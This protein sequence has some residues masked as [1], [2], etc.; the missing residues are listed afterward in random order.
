[1]KKIYISG[2]ISG[3]PIESVVDKFAR[4]AE[5]LMVKGFEPVNPID[6]SPYHV[7]KTWEDYMRDDI[8]AL[9]KCDA[10]YMLND[11][12]QSRGARIEYVIAKE[13]GL[14]IIFEGEL[15]Q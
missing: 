12:G 2:K 4:N 9:M 7:S 11:W 14:E 5:F 6:V 13:L 8:S 1:M 15:N 10:I 3:L